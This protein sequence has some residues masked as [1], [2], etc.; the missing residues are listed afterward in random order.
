MTLLSKSARLAILTDMKLKI[1]EV[2][3]YVL[4]GA[5]ATGFH[6]LVLYSCIEIFNFS[7]IGF[8]NFCASLVGISFSFVG[9]RYFVFRKYNQRIVP[10]FIKFI[11]LYSLVAFLH[12]AFLYIWSD[13]L[14]NN[15]NY[16][17]AIAVAIQF[18][19]GYYSS[20]YFVFKKSADQIIR[21][22]S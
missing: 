12:G 11:S 19:L 15:Y 1:K 21:I 2:L 5:V 4:N 17:F 14:L 7:S 22:N 16:G 18:L 13:V 20:K 9:N 6:Y 10:Q 3:R 8:A